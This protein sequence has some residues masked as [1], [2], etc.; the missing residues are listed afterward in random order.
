MARRPD[1]RRLHLEGVLNQRIN[2]S[3]AAREQRLALAGRSLAVRIEGSGLT[4]Q[5]AAEPQHVQVRWL[6]GDGGEAST[7]TIAATPLTLLGLLRAST[8]AD[9]A[10]SDAELAGDMETLEGFAQLLR[11]ARP[12][13]EEELSGV[14]GDVLAHEVAEAARR[15]AGWGERAFTALQLNTSEFLQEEIRQLPPR[16]E[17]ERFSREVER[18]REDTDRA[19]QRLDR[20]LQ[21]HD[22]GAAWD[23]SD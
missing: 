17:V 11:L 8:V 13:P 21:A 7:A 9:I 2:D 23:G 20:L 12:D 19:A 1:N 15:L 18:L 3:A 16:L 4:L 6:G 10:A 5:L 14:L 22:G